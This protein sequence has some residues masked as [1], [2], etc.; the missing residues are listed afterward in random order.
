MKKTI[1]LLFAILV[2]LPILS[3]QRRAED[4]RDKEDPMT[5]GQGRSIGVSLFGPGLIGV[6]VRFAM[7]ENQLEFIASYAPRVDFYDDTNGDLETDSYQ[8]IALSAGYNLLLGTKDKFWKNKMIKNYI[9]P[10]L[11]FSID[12]INIFH[13]GVTWHRE[14]FRYHQRN[15]SRGFDL[16]LRYSK[17]LGDDFWLTGDR[18]RQDNRVSLYISFDWNWFR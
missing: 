8:G 2:S 4:I 9:S 1:I 10:K 15:Y 6:P 3:G 7:G 14:A 18:E 5:F 16:G 17:A 11:G 13:F 12:A